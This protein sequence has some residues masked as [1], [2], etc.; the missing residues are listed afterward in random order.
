[1]ARGRLLRL[2]M[3]LAA[4]VVVAAGT[5]ACAGCS[6]P[7]S[8][9]TTQAQTVAIGPRETLRRL[10]ELRSERKYRE[11]PTLIVPQR[12][13]DVV[14]FLMAV[15][16]FLAANRR[17]CNWLRDNVGLGL[18][19]TIDQ[20]Y[21]TADLAVYAG[22]DLGIFSRHVELLDAS[23]RDEQA[24]VS[25]AVENR[26]PA[27]VAHLRKIKG[28][29]RYDPGRGYSEH[30]PAAFRDMAR[31]LELVLAELES[32]RIPAD[33]LWVGPTPLMEKVKSRLRRGVRLLSKARAAAEAAS[34]E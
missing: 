26:L 12:G 27:K 34:E 30:L 16:D 6:R 29:W 17:L 32:G 9:A 18:S 3:T 25:F 24:T 20:S 13:N 21:V 4:G 23:I 31:S 22:D 14:E 7:P 15:D 8:K 33:D 2:V 11:L 1:M 19:Q 5:V 28:T 10:I